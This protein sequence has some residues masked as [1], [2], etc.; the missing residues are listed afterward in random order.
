MIRR[1]NQHCSVVQGL[2]FSFSFFFF[3]WEARCCFEIKGKHHPKTKFLSSF[4]HLHLYEFLNSAEDILKNVGSI[5]G[6]GGY[7][8]L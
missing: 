1:E 6:G 2:F 3:G 8:L 5:W 7:P 4:T